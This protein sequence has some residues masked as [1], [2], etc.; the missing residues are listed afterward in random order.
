MAEGSARQHLRRAQPRRDGRRLLKAPA[1]LPVIPGPPQDIAEPEQ[2]HAAPLTTGM[3]KHRQQ[4][5]RPR[6]V[7]GRVLIRQQPSRPVTG[8]DRELDGQGRIAQRGRLGEVV[9]K[10]GQVR[11]KVVLEQRLQHQPDGAVQRQPTGGRHVLVEGLAHQI[12]GEGIPP[13]NRYVLG[14]D[15]GP[16]GLRH[17]VGKAPDA[18][19]AYA[20]QDAEFEFPADDCRHPEVRDRLRL[21]PSHSPT[22]EGLNLLGKPEHGID[23]RLASVGQA[24]VG[25]QDPYHLADEERVAGGDVVHLGD[26]RFRG[27]A[28]RRSADVGAHLRAAEPPQRD[29]VADPC[30][31]GE[32][33]GQL[34][35]ALLGLPV[36]AKQHDA[37]ARDCLGEE[38]QQQQRRRIRRM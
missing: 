30:Q 19:T 34:V 28:T 31:L 4:P 17:G 3:L 35:D 5:Q 9:R 12:V 29:P 33:L 36:G 11:L 38:P 27:S 24:R 23:H 18:E 6:V 37:L 20:V 13:R 7:P 1:S 16:H 8:T 32:Q 22:D 26:H 21:Q 15:P 25:Q 2:E 10:L 14:E